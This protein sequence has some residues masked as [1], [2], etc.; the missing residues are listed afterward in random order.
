MQQLYKQWFAAT[1]N[2]SCGI[3]LT[4]FPWFLVDS[5]RVEIEGR[6]HVI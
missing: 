5:N 4:I 6:T 3:L 2:H 1:F